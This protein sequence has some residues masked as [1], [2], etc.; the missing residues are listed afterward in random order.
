MKIH[1]ACLDLMVV[2]SVRGCRRRSCRF[3]SVASVGRASFCWS[4]YYYFC[5]IDIVGITTSVLLSV[6]LLSGACCCLIG[7][8]VGVGKFIWYVLCCISSSIDGS[9]LSNSSFF[10]LFY[11]SSFI[12]FQELLVLQLDKRASNKKNVKMLPLLWMLFMMKDNHRPP[13]INL[14]MIINKTWSWQQPPPLLLPPSL[15]HHLAW[16]P[17]VLHHANLPPQ[18]RRSVPCPNVPSKPR[19]V[20]FAWNMVVKWSIDSAMPWVVTM[21][22][23]RVDTASVITMIFVLPPLLP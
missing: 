19:L 7:C 14:K 17:M 21:L 8:G 1:A 20:D 16:C 18:G 9:S 4:S 5:C 11:I 2:A 12:F 10:Y 3:C 15:H 13:V 23:K 22:P 6:C